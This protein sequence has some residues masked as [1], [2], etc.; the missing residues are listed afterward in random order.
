MSSQFL[1]QHEAAACQRAAER[2][3]DPVLAGQLWQEQAMWL[4]LAGISAAIE[5]LAASIVGLNA[6]DEALEPV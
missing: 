4:G 1:Y 3:N 5:N 2:A 6:S